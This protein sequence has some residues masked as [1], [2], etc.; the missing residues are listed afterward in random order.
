MYSY[1]EAAL[2][3][4][5]SLLTSIRQ[6]CFAAASAT[7][8][9]SM[10]ERLGGRLAWQHK[11]GARE[12][13]AALWKAIQS[14]ATGN[15]DWQRQL[16]L[17]MSWIP[18]EDDPEFS[19]EHVFADHAVATVAYAIRCLISGDPQDA[20]WAARRAY[21]AADQ[22]AIRAAGVEFGVTP[23]AERIVLSHPI[24][25]RELGRQKED[26]AALIDKGE[27]GALQRSAFSQELLTVDEANEIA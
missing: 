10:F 15:E 6:V 23:D 22:A 17:V 1:D 3:Q 14:P 13:T 2:V 27:F 20:G 26:L 25:Q 4:A 8:Q 12:V 18:D 19:I 7:R 5:L 11:A 24:V 21:E 16:D 9:L